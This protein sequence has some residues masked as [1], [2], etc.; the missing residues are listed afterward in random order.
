MP[1]TAEAGETTGLGE[2]VELDEA[3]HREVHEALEEENEPLAAALAGQ[4]HPA[5]Q[6]ALIERLEP[7]LRPELVRALGPQLDPET[8]SYLDDTVR[9]DVLEAIGPKAAGAAV[10]QLDT[11]DAVEV[12]SELEPEEQRAI[13]AEVPAPERLVIEQGLAYPEYSAGRLMQ[14]EVV[15][16]PEFWTVG[17]AVDWLRARPELPDTFYDI[18]L[19]DPRFAPVGA[20]PL[21][22]LVRGTREAALRDLRQKELRSFSPETDQE[23]V[24]RAFHRYGLV[25]APVV[26]ADGRLLGVLT[27]DDIVNV[28]QEEAEEDFLRLGGVAEADPYASSL[29]TSLRRLPWLVVN[30]ATAILASLV[31]DQ[32]EGQIAQL[33]A[34]A[35]LAPMVASMG[36]NAGTQTL[37]VTVR[38]IALRVIGQGVPLRAVRKELVVGAL[39]GIVFFGIGWLTAFVWFRQAKL[40]LVFGAAMLVNLLAAGFAG[41]LIPLVLERLGFDPAVSSGVFLTTVTDCVGFFAFLALATHFLL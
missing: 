12:L 28:I 17:A 24:A 16:L 35:V 29:Q 40:A 19:V 38:A 4:L 26:G 9:D 25:S 34:L 37:T 33:V 31:I 39:N 23:E 11:D 14:R 6:A 2:P 18:Y 15:A 41:V 1:P 32:F 3:L 5:D 20:V 13:L 21:S 30:L 7:R 36:G 10:A 22:H 8:L 27:V